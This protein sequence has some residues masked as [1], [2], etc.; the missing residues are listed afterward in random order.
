MDFDYFNFK[1]NNKV[2]KG[3]LI[4]SQPLM[5]DL[6]DVEDGA[7]R[8][9]AHGDINLITLLM[10]ASADGLEILTKEEKWIPIIS[11]QLLLSLGTPISSSI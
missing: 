11:A 4:L 1:S 3:S 10:G 7:V 2:T 9:A 5:K 8:A 6:E